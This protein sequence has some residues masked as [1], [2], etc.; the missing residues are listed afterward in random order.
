MTLQELLARIKNAKTKTEAQLALAAY[1][2]PDAKIE[3]KD[4]KQTETKNDDVQVQVSAAPQTLENP[5]YETLRRLYILL[6]AEEAA[7]A[8]EKVNAAAV[9]KTKQKANAKSP[10][11]PQ[12]ASTPIINQ[13]PLRVLFESLLPSPGSKRSPA[14]TG[15]QEN[16][17]ELLQRL[18]QDCKIHQTDNAVLAKLKLATNTGIHFIQ[19]KVD[20][21]SE[22]HPRRAMLVTALGPKTAEANEQKVPHH[23]LFG[24]KRLIAHNEDMFTPTTTLCTSA[25]IFNDVS[26]TLDDSFKTDRKTRY[27]FAKIF[28]FF[29][30]WIRGYTGSQLSTNGTLEQVKGSF[31]SIQKRIAPVL[32]K[33]KDKAKKQAAEQEALLERCDDDPYEFCD[34]QEALISPQSMVFLASGANLVRRGEL[35]QHCRKSVAEQEKEH[36][37]Q[38]LP[39]KAIKPKDP[40]TRVDLLPSLRIDPRESKNQKFAP[41][42][43][44][45][46]RRLHERY[47]N[48]KKTILATIELMPHD[49]EEQVKA[50]EELRIQLQAEFIQAREQYLNPRATPVKAV[51]ESKA[52]NN[53]TSSEVLPVHTL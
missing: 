48:A 53:T 17:I 36:K 45:V 22:K 13:S 10:L 39:T 38:K 31:S 43:Y 18:E 52:S 7:A 23:S 42:F 2:A 8:E 1:F 16:R 4:E 32:Q 5:D 37:K 41:A 40:F 29:R 25:V 14:Q 21:M 26:S 24:L 19:Q 9:R 44:E 20:S 50:F 6:Q 33:T 15:Q 47:Y 3:A 28:E 11:Q 46:A 34:F 27:T 35:D 51:A 30:D 49:I 12:G